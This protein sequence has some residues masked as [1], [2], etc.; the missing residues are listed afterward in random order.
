[1]EEIDPQ[2]FGYTPERRRE[3]AEELGVQIGED[4]VDHEVTRRVFE[5]RFEEVAD[6]PCVVRWRVPTVLVPLAEAESR[7]CFGGWTFAN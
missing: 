4:L 5:K 6:D 3:R 2:W 1:L 7:R